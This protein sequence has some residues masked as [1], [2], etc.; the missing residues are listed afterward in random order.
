MKL[1]I[2]QPYLFPYI[3]YFQLVNAVDHF[4]L[5]DDVQYINRGWINRNRI[6]INGKSHLYVFSVKKDSHLLN[7]N[8]REFADNYCYEKE[9]FIKTLEWYKSAPFYEDTTNLIKQILDI[10][11]K[12]ISRM[13]N[14]SIKF[15][16]DYLDIKTKITASSNI[17]INRDLKAED[18]IIKINKY[19]GSD[20]YINS[21]G[22][23]YLYNKRRFSDVGIDLK[24]IKTKEI[25]YKQFNNEFIPNLSIIDVLMFNSV[26]NIKQLLNEYEIVTN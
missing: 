21:I 15:I 20:V 19:F 24:F 8:Q 11:D 4:V 16:C 13:I 18:R 25:V 6:L 3:G 17:I 5:Y 2:M 22:G 9:K 23:I 7:I 12:N 10:S 14:N 1:A 26:E